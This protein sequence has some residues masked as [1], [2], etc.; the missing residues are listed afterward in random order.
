MI[1]PFRGER[2]F[3]AHVP[4]T[5]SV[6]EASSHISQAADI[7]NQPKNT[8]NDITNYQQR[9]KE[10]QH[11]SNSANSRSLN[12]DTAPSF[13][14]QS[15]PVNSTPK[16]QSTELGLHWSITESTANSI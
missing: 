15:R 14:G 8:Q 10:F 16:P 1:E 13:C 6:V 12:R 3:N 2:G 9:R 5:E 7:P 4:Q 11:P